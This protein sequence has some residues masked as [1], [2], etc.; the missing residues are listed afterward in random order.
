MD[1]KKHCCRWFLFLFLLA[2]AGQSSTD[3]T[4]PSYVSTIKAS[5]AAGNYALALDGI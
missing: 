4:L 5:G 1:M 2:L 3:L